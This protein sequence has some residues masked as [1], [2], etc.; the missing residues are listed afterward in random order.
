MA[1]NFLINV[2]SVAKG[3]VMSIGLLGSKPFEIKSTLYSVDC[4]E[5]I[6]AVLHPADN[7]TCPQTV[8][9]DQYPRYYRL[10]R[11]FERLTGVPVILD[12]SFKNY[13]GPIVTAPTEALKYFYGMGL[14]TL[15]L[16]DFII[17][18]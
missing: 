16:G 10:I 9:E 18:K 17:E 8:W 4:R 15:V 14:D 6:E 12:M 2:C 13:E 3:K 7:T 1:P 11:K 5:D